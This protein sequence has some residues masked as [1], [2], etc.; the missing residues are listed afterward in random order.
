MKRPFLALAVVLIL[1]VLGGCGYFQKK[2]EPPPLP[3]IEETKPPLTMKGD[4]FKSYPWDALPK[5]RKDGNDPDTSL[6]TVKDGDTLEKI[7]EKEMGNAALAGGLTAYNELTPPRVS[8]G[9]KVVIPN[10]IIGMSSQIMVKSKGDKEFGPPKPFD[11]EIKRGDEYKLRF[12]P[13]VTGYAYVFREGPKGTEMLYPAQEKKIEKKPEKKPGKKNKRTLEPV[14]S[15]AASSRVNA[16]EAIEIPTGKKGF[17]YDQKRAGNRVFVFLSLREIPELEDLKIKQ[18]VRVE[19][20]D[21]VMNR[22]K[23]GEI[24]TQ[25]PYNLLRIMSP[26]EVLGF[27]LNLDG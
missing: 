9:D 25:R 7:A 21:D 17:A 6:Y 1:C 26:T 18:K 13:D 11:T 8:A 5:P 27:T 4:Y 12:E 22:V 20:L 3:P 2:D 15:Q 16:Y 19:E 23:Q 24:F 14:I 10:P